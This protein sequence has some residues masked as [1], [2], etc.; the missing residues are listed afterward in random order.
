VKVARKS[1]VEKNEE[2]GASFKKD[3]EES[4]KK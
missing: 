2:Q 3:L 4:V 1:H